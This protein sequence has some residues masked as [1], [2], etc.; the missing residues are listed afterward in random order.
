MRR[1]LLT[2]LTLTACGCPA[3]AADASPTISDWAYW[4]HY[5]CY[6]TS[7]GRQPANDDRLISDRYGS[8]VVDLDGPET[9]CAGAEVRRAATDEDPFAGNDGADFTCYDVDGGQRP[10]AK[11]L[12][13]VIRPE[14]FVGPDSPTEGTPMA[15]TLEHAETLCVPTP[16][17]TT[18][19]TVV[20]PSAADSLDQ[21]EGFNLYYQCYD[22]EG[23]HQPAD[24]D[25]Y[26]RDWIGPPPASGDDPGRR[27]DLDQPLR[28][29]APAN[30]DGDDRVNLAGASYLCFDMDGGQFAGFRHYFFNRLTVPRLDNMLLG[31]ADSLCAPAKVQ[32]RAG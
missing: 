30:R 20:S 1:R 11:V 25:R 2:L 6:D 18:A 29:C 3:A 23:G 24:D 13:D 9:F 31:Q 15:L 21:D 10:H 32:L 28:L 7:G 16:R 19:D 22:V 5:Q 12:V 27:V 14:G 26:V 8:R 4:S 17:G